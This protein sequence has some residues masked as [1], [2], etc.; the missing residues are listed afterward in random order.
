MQN[1]GISQQGSREP[2]RHHSYQNSQ[3]YS[4]AQPP[5][6]NI[7]Q[8]TPQGSHYATT[9][10]NSQLPGSLQPG[11]P[12]ASSA[13]TAPSGVPTL[14]QIQ[15]QSSHS[16]R[17]ATASQ[18]HN[19]SRS[20]PTGM[21]GS[22]YSPYTSTPEGSKFTTPIN[23]RY[24]G[25][26]AGHESAFSPLG[27]ADIRSFNEIDAPPSATND[28]MSIV[29]SNSSYVAPYPIYAFDWCKWPVQHQNAGD[30]GGKMA[31]GSYV[32]DGHNFVSFC[33]AS[34]ASDS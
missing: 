25:S 3:E 12:G 5:G 7:Q 33:L 21:D 4:S 14:P 8:S 17:P 10:S 18:T 31:L 19:Y 23:H 20:S 24:G 13:A 29:P 22:K 16:S 9:A 27:L 30:S 6:I 34:Q 26:Q 28:G 11:R 1:P 2:G 32:E 15:A